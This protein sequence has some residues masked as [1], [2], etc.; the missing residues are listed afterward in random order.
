[1]LEVQLCLANG[2]NCKTSHEIVYELAESIL[3]KLPAAPG[4][5]KA[6]KAMFEGKLWSRGS[7]GLGNQ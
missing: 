1:M 4:M 5:E 6:G 2:G 7:Q 3:S